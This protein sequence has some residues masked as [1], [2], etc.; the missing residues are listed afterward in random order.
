MIKA[1]VFDMAGT[2]V[3]E[4]NIVYRSVRN[5]LKLYGFTFDLEDVMLRIGGMSKKEGIDL[6]IRE[7]D[8]E[9]YSEELVDKVFESFLNGVEERYASDEDIKEKEGAT[10]LF[11]YL[12]SKDIKV[13]LD[14]GYSRRTVDILM[15]KM[16]WQD[17]GL[18]DYSVTSDEVNKGRPSP[19]MINK[20][21]DKF[22][23][24]PEQMIKVGDTQ[25]DID[26][27]HNAGCKIIVGI[28][29]DKHDRD[30]L[31][32][33]GATHAIEELKEIITIIDS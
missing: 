9:R 21:A 3:D 33:M 24:S 23:I 31:M 27:G 14:T 15:D 25:S 32:K 28:T 12:K 5:A 7:K 6:L 18:I 22:K 20:I 19:D 16:R 1:V 30:E 26:E 10:S 8:P 2:T 11:K 29:S 13:C 17:S 4:A